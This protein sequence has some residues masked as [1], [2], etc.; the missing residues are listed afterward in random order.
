MGGNISDTLEKFARLH[1]N[2]PAVHAPDY[3]T[4]DYGSLQALIEDTRNYLNNHG[5]GRGDRV[6]LIVTSPAIALVAYLC[7]VCSA[8]AVPINSNQTN[9]EL[10]RA[11][12]EAGIVAA[13]ASRDLNGV[14]AVL[15]QLSIPRLLVSNSTVDAAGAFYLTGGV[16]GQPRSS[17]PVAPTDIACIHMSSG[18]TGRA[19]AMLLSHETLLHRAASD[20]KILQLT[21]DD[22]LINFRPPYLT[23]PL[24]I[25]FL[26]PIIAGSSIVVPPFSM[27][28]RSLGTL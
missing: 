20:I 11:I 2:A 1:P 12:K 23:G 27:R 15:T 22:V 9:E 8:I 19:K 14:A 18:T 10:K 21:Q 28:I 7:T 16:E 6:A 26:T 25:G 17:G 3:V 13:I 5:I 24:D 4:L